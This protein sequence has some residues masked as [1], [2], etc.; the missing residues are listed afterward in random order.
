MKKA[1]PFSILI[2]LSVVF[3]LSQCKKEEDWSYCNCGI[4][5]WV[6]T[7]QGSGDY[8]EDDQPDSKQVEVDMIIEQFS[9]DNLTVK[10]DVTDEYS[11]TFYAEKDD[12]TYYITVNSN[13]KSLTMN[14]KKKGM[15]YK[16]IG[17]AKNFHTETDDDGNTYTV[18]DKVISFDVTR[19]GQ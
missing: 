9:S 11:E 13:Y 4:E 8:Y 6:G 16:L 2:L 12:S 5:S 1:T 18:F 17:T 15:D 19:A 10:I 14:L 3:I 7:Y